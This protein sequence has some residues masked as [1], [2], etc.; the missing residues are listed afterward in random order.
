[1]TWLCK[2]KDIMQNEEE[3]KSIGTK[4][5][6]RM[7]VEKLRLKVQELLEEN[8]AADNIE[9]MDKTELLIDLDEDQKRREKI[10]YE[11]TEQKQLIQSSNKSGRQKA[12]EFKHNHIQLMQFPYQNIG[13]ISEDQGIV[14][15]PNIPL[16]CLSKEETRIL[17]MIKIM[18]CNEMSE[19]KRNINR[20]S[21]NSKAWSSCILNDKK[22]ANYIFDPLLRFKEKKGDDDDVFDTKHGIA[23]QPHHLLYTTTA[24]KTTHQ[25]VTQMI[26]LRHSN[27]DM[28]AGF[29]NLHVQLKNIKNAMI[30]KLESAY[31]RVSIITNNL[32][33][34]S[35]IQ[36]PGRT[37]DICLERLEIDFYNASQTTGATNE[38]TT[39]VKSNFQRGLIDMMDGGVDNVK[40]SFSY[41]I[42]FIR[43]NVHT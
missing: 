6:M 13:S 16:Q 33:C 3:T 32:G 40:V 30:S 27:R 19:M 38:D 7:K 5:I 25:R 29:N 24:I 41:A 42:F 8:A 36:K 28:V 1:M 2:A 11:I 34:V 31:D 15:V 23:Y 22:D 26:L 9:K 37:N 14:F 10:E 18:R 35:T 12:L 20:T 43:M 4:N 17:D 21:N 39:L